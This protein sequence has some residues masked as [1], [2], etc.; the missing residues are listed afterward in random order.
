MKNDLLLHL[1]T[2]EKKAQ[3][4][5]RLLAGDINSACRSVA[6]GK[7]NACI[8]DVDDYVIGTAEFKKLQQSVLETGVLA[9]ACPSRAGKW[10]VVFS[11]AL[12]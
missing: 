12:T 6:S 10:L 11:P 2:R 4:R 3:K 8:E 5:L 9:Q 1:R 7:T